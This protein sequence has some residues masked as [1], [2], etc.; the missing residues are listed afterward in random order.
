MCGENFAIGVRMGCNEPNLATS[1]KVAKLLE[2]GGADFL[3]ISTGISSRVYVRL[4]KPENFLYSEKIYAAWQINK[5]VKIPVIAVGDITKAE[6]AIDILE[7]NTH[8]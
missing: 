6:D 2:Q 3:D 7:K 8:L 1:I 5:Q 4:D